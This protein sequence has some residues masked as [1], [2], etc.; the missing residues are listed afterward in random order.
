MYTAHTLVIGQAIYAPENRRV[1][2][3]LIIYIDSL[4]HYGVTDWHN[5]IHKMEMRLS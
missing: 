4:V 1:R 5:L 3:F 2:G